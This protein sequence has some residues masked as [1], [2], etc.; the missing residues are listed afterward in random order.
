MKYHDLIEMPLLEVQQ[1]AA[2]NP[3]HIGA[4]NAIRELEHRKKA[5][6]VLKRLGQRS[7]VLSGKTKKGFSHSGPRVPTKRELR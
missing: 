1:F 4:Q 2:L 3:G 5:L 7:A 6:K